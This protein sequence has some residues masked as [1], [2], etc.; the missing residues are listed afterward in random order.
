MNKP[1][2]EQLAAAQKA[3]AEVMSALICGLERVRWQKVSHRVPAPA[4]AANRACVTVHEVAEAVV[5]RK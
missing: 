4:L 1:N 3:N 5:N 2:M